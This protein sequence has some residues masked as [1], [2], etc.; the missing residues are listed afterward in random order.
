MQGKAQKQQLSTVA[1]KQG[2]PTMKKLVVLVIILAS[3]STS[4]LAQEPKKPWVDLPYLGFISKDN[5]P[6]YQI[7]FDF[8]IEQWENGKRTT[9]RYQLWYLTCEYP[10]TWYWQRKNQTHC[11][12]ERT[13]IDRWDRPDIG[14]QSVVTVHRHDTDDGTLV[15]RQVDWEKR[16][17]DFGVVY[18]LD[19]TPTEV[20]IRLKYND[21]NIFLDSFEAMTIHRGLFPDMKMSVIEYKIPEYTYAM[22]VPIQMKGYKSEE[23]KRLD[24][25][26]A[27]LGENDR[28]I[29]SRLKED[30]QL[31]P[32]PDEKTLRKILPSYD[33][34]LKEKRQPPPVEWSK[35]V[36]F[37]LDALREKLVRAGL[38]EDAQRKILD[39]FSE[40]LLK[41]W[42][43]PIG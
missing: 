38:S 30:P 10:P 37:M 41:G 13:V 24:E 4:S 9:H 34:M 16:I 21:N 6:H 3:G 23:G 20:R 12:L 28:R 2:L 35:V 32:I 42:I 19:P 43:P 31:L 22:E 18:P 15:L 7:I 1:T 11:T 17:L 33:Q 36:R 26:I 27:S 39:L 40:E 25:V 5:P 29:W 14:L 8:A